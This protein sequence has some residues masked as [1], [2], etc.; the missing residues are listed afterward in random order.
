MGIGTSVDG[1]CHQ[2]LTGLQEWLYV[3]VRGFSACT[4]PQGPANPPRFTISLTL[5]GVRISMAISD[6]SRF[7][8][9]LAIPVEDFQGRATLALTETEMEELHTLMVKE[10][11]SRDFYHLVNIAM[12]ADLLFQNGFRE[13][14]WT[15][16]ALRKQMNRVQVRTF[17]QGDESIHEHISNRCWPLFRHVRRTRQ[18]PGTRIEEVELAFS[19]LGNPE[20]LVEKYEPGAG[21]GLPHRNEA[22]GDSRL[23]LGPC[24]PGEGP[25]LPSRCID[26]EWGNS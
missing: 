1:P 9:F 4:P 21:G 16:G 20:Q 10:D 17:T 2:T 18:G 3:V 7:E 22:R 19:P 23:D 11:V 25:D 14:G 24:G 26:Q 13:K 15:I 12:K 8:Q 6:L 5:K